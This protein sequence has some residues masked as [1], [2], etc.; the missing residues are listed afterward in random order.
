MYL[1]DILLNVLNQ[2]TSF[3]F[4]FAKNSQNK[5]NVSLKNTKINLKF[6]NNYEID[7]SKDELLLLLSLI[8]NSNIL[9]RL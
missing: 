6:I 1:I 3:F 2:L 4:H 5:P 7:G 8:D 9:N